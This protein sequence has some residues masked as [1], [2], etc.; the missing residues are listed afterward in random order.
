MILEMKKF[1]V[2][3]NSRSAGREAVLRVKQIINGFKDVDEIVL[4]FNE[5]EILTPSFADE[6]IKGVKN[7]YPAKEVKIIN[8]EKNPVIKDTLKQLNLI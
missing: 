8:T 1:G 4:D 3:L 7:Q 2:I 5:V 6:F